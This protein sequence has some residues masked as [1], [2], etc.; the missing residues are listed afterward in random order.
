MEQ[1]QKEII[2]KYSFKTRSWILKIAM[3]TFLIICTNFYYIQKYLSLIFKLLVSAIYLFKIKFK[4]MGKKGKGMSYEQK[5]DKM[6]AIFH[7]NVKEY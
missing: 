1:S 4:K 5:R 7:K 3:G 2:G 6:L